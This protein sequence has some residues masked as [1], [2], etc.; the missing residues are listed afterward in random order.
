MERD[1]HDESRTADEIRE[2]EEE[3]GPGATAGTEYRHPND[4]IGG[5]AYGGDMMLP[6]TG[7]LYNPSPSTGMPGEPAHPKDEDE[8]PR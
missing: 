7:D 1:R 4:P 6:P 5:T 2:E 3:S 8:E